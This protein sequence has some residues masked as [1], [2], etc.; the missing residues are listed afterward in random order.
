MN[1]GKSMHYWLNEAEESLAKAIDASKDGSVP[2]QNLY[3][4]APIIYS[5]RQKTNDEELIH[6]MIDANDEQVKTDWSFDER[7]KEQY[8]FHFV[9]SYLFCFVV[10]GKID[11]FKYDRIMECVNGEMSLFTDDY[12]V[13]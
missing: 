10:A 7:S 11:E 13:E 1:K 6:E 5:E 8:K 12:D 9:S 3:M 2:L 4:L